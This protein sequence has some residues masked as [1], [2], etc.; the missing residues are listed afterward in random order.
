MFTLSKIKEIINDPSSL[1]VGSEF[2]FLDDKPFPD[3]LVYGQEL[4]KTILGINSLIPTNTLDYFKAININLDLAHIEDHF[5]RSPFFLHG[6]E[7]FDSRR[8]LIPFYKKI[9]VNLLKTINGI[10]SQYFENLPQEDH[11]KIIKIASD[12]IELAFK[13]IIANDLGCEISELPDMP[14][15]IFHFFPARNALAAYNSRINKLKEF[16]ENKL[17][18]LNRDTDECWMLMSIAIMGT[19][20]LLG[21]L[22]Y[23]VMHEREGLSG[24]I[25]APY[26]VNPV[27]IIGR[28]VKE[29]VTLNNLELNP[30]QQIYITPSLVYDLQSDKPNLDSDKI[31]IAFGHGVH[32]CPGRKIALIILESYFKGWLASNIDGESKNVKFM[33]DLINRPVGV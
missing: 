24:M 20:T 33:K 7:H 11:P 15:E 29:K 1:A 22:V 10:T 27:T 2:I 9:E 5:R 6:K 14:G 19:E 25:A 26:E 16:I 18:R 3:L 12:Y 21:P 4:S 17:F 23:G 32:I 8:K 31:S 28:I 30:G 13:N